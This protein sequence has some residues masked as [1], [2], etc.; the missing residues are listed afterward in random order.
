MNNPLPQ[1][2]TTTELDIA[3]LDD[4]TTDVSVFLK[5]SLTEEFY[6]LAN[7]GNAGDAL[8]AKATFD[9]FD[10]L[11]LRYQSL[12]HSSLEN[13]DLVRNQ[14]IVLGGGGNFA[15]GGYNH[16]AHLL[17]HIHR[18]AKLVIVLPH[19]I[20]GNNDLLSELGG[21]VILFCRERTSYTH[22]K[23]HA[24]KAK[25]LLAH[26]MAFLLNVQSVLSFKPRYI[27]GIASRYLLKA[28][29]NKKF[30]EHPTRADY[31]R[32]LKTRLP[33]INSTLPRSRVANFY[34]TD[35]EK[36]EI[37]L[38]DD[39]IDVSLVF[40]YG[41]TSPLK[42]SFTVYHLFKYL[43]SFE[44]INTNRLHVAI[45]AGLLGKTVNFSPN[46]Y[47]KCR[48]VYE[49]SLMKQFPNVRWVDT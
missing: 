27:R 15:E 23:H 19:T 16:Y 26:D 48:A 17:T 30:N 42:S 33:F 14:I 9:L 5:K 32:A 13:L 37:P 45:S 2:N 7:P 41:I 44:I 11:S 31:L 49:H 18:H 1:C 22:V 8:M 47:F 24:K 28:L 40:L 43:E 38:P 21:N 3:S 20:H 29:G 10:K 46:G 4:E 12:E 35:I 6:Y 34:R 36:T 25:V 39:N